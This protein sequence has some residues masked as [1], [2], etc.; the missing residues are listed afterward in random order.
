M[1]ITNLVEAIESRML[2]SAGQLDHSFGDRGLVALSRGIKTG[3]RLV[4][5]ESKRG[6]N[7]NGDAASFK[8]SKRGRG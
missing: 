8:E 2:L 7:Q 3:T 5:R 6:R 4:S 1:S